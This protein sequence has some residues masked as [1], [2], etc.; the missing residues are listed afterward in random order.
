MSN[1]RRDRFERVAS[2]R[3]DRVIKDIQLLA[4]CSNTN[5]YEYTSSDVE[6]MLKAIKAELKLL[7]AAFSTGVRDSDEGFKF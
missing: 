2:K 5:N 6:K 7:E 1:G 4:N 3:V